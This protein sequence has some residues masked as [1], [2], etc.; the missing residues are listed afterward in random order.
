LFGREAPDGDLIIDPARPRLPAWLLN[1]LQRQVLALRR[2]N[3]DE[4]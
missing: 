1:F 3:V 2:D 4:R